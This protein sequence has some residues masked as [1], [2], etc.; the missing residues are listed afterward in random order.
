MH[1]PPTRTASPVRLAVFAGLAALVAASALAAPLPAGER[2]HRPFDREERIERLTERHAE[3]LTRALDLTAAQQTTLARLQDELEA[4][5]RPL[6]GEMRAAHET[7][8]TLLDASSPD[9]L[10]VGTQAI[11]LDRARDRMHAARE[12]FETELA[13]A[14]TEAQRTTFRAL[15]ELRSDEARF[16]R[17]FRERARGGHRRR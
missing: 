9:A 17:P 15:Q 12:R 14:L 11:A 13:A 2:S 6:S 5:L 16:D 8:R 3:R 10:A 4:T 7:L 1:A